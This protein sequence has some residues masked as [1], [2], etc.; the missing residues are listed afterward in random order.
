MRSIRPILLDHSLPF[1]AMLSSPGLLRLP[2]L[3]Q[4]LMATLVQR[5]VF[6]SMQSGLG[7]D[8]HD[9]FRRVWQNIV[10]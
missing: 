3:Q 4:A 2:A 7:R 8:V 6:G 9:S 1:N 10:P 5:R